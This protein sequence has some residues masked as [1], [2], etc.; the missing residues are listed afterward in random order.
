MKKHNTLIIAILVMIT[1]VFS[2]LVLKSA[3]I[4]L[5]SLLGLILLITIFSHPYF[6]LVLYLVLL[7]IRPQDFISSL[8][9]LRIMLNLA[10]ITITFFLIHKIINREKIEIFATRQNI[11]MFILLLIVLL[12]DLSNFNLGGAWDS[13]NGFLTLLF[14]FLLITLITG[15]K[16]KTLYWSI[17]F[18]CLFMAINGLLQQFNGVDLFGQISTHGRIQWVGIF[19][20]PNDFALVLVSSLPIILFY[21]FEKKV[22]L[23]AKIGLIAMLCIFFMAIYYTNSRGGYLAVIAILGSFSV[24]IWGVKKGLIAGTILIIIALALAPTRMSGISPHGQSASGRIYAWMQGLVILKSHPVLGVGMY[25]FTQYSSRA[26]HSAFIKCLA[27]L[28]LVGFFVWTALIYTSFKDLIR[29]ERTSTDTTLILYSKIIQISFIGFLTSAFFL[30]Q[31]Y[32]PIIYILFA[33]TALLSLHLRAETGIKFPN[34]T[35]N[36][37]AVILILE[38]VSI[39]V[40]KIYMILY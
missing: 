37:F 23:I 11:L 32:S 5:A 12:S 1:M 25:N 20:D 27:E 10:L 18:A 40:Y 30:S 39:M 31:T 19:G 3:I 22:N 9:P 2:L 4:A 24:K 21:L 14:P 26:S 33:L 7:Y 8:V 16:Y 28:G 6:G 36:E 34:M 17:T 29:I 15:Q 35:R 38:G 13:F